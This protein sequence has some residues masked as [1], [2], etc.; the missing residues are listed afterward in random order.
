M[1]FRGRMN[2]AIYEPNFLATNS[3]C[4]ITHGATR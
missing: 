3:L 2:L 1:K 4:H